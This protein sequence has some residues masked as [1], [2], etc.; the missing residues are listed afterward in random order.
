MSKLLRNY[1]IKLLAR[2]ELVDGVPYWSTT[3]TTEARPMANPFCSCHP[4]E[5]LTDSVAY[6]LETGDF[7][8]LV[9][10]GLTPRAKLDKILME[11][12]KP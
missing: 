12:Y 7:E 10:T 9:I 3:K 6:V 11:E 4:F 1:T 8:G 2:T 5:L